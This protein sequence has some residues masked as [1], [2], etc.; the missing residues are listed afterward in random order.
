MR[1]IKTECI[2]ECYYDKELK[3]CGS[4]FRTL[5]EIAE[6][7]KKKNNKLYEFENIITMMKKLDDNNV[8][9]EDRKLNESKGIQDKTKLFGCMLLT[10]TCDVDNFIWINNS[11]LFH[12]LEEAEAFGR[13]KVSNDV[14]VY[15]YKIEY[16]YLCED[17]N[18]LL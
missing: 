18:G 9:K 7:G 15:D 5:D 3:C 16:Y 12:S 4:C 1:N 11:T 10:D 6:A 17:F 14:Y 13:Y 8:T 2:L